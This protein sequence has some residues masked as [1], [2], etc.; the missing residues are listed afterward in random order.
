MDSLSWVKR[1][2]FNHNQYLEELGSCSAPGS[3]REKKAYFEA[4]Y[5]AKREALEKALAD[6]KGAV[7]NDGIKL[8]RLVLLKG[9][10]MILS[11]VM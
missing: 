9:K 7:D 4:Y 2:S 11:H 3:V 6:E 1:S 8:N 10:Y 5:K